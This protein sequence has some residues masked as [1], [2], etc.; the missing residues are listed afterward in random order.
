MDFHE[1]VEEANRAEKSAA[2]RKQY[3]ARLSLPKTLD[4]SPEEFV[5]MDYKDLRNDYERMVKVAKATGM[6]FRQVAAPVVQPE[7]EQKPVPKAEK[8]PG[9]ERQKPR[10]QLPIP[11]PL[12]KVEST[13]EAPSAP[14]KPVE[15]APGREIAPGARKQEPAPVQEEKPEPAE[16]EV[17]I[18][19]EK[20]GAPAKKAYAHEDE[21]ITFEREAPGPEKE[22]EEK[23]GHAEEE[24]AAPEPTQEPAPEFERRQERGSERERELEPESESKQERETGQGRE[25]E[26]DETEGAPELEPEPTKPVHEVQISQETK[27]AIGE[28]SEIPYIQHHVVISIAV[29][30]LLSMDPENEAQKKYSE[31]EEK[32]P[33]ESGKIDES[34]VKQR[35]LELTKQLFREK[36]VNQ[37]QKIKAEI[38]SLREMLSKK[39][40]AAKRPLS[41]VASFFNTM[42]VDQKMELAAAKESLSKEYKEN[43]ARTLDAFSSSLKITRSEEERKRIYETLV[44]DLENLQSQV[45]SLGD[46]YESFFLREHTLSL[47]K[48][49]D[50][51]ALKSEKTVAQGIESK[52]GE[53]KLEY[54]AEFLSFQEAVKK[55]VASITK[56]KKHEA[57][58][59]EMSKEMEL[60]LSIV[61]MSAEELM[62]YVH[63]RHPGEYKEL[64]SGKM[65][66][67]EFLSRARLLV[68]KDSGLGKDTINKYFGEI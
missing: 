11:K 5:D 46:K 19:E 47:Q 56:T 32:I 68:A 61:N 31:L 63:S 22:D 37:R 16:A 36:S 64:E 23:S 54:A 8:P 29:P 67:L 12:R 21:K 57:L 53:M 45:E 41:Y 50:L 3:P 52:I 30:P 55:E 1:L 6:G 43:L 26:R 24:P 38:T 27:A 2:E 58:E 65:T 4:F 9:Q 13:S 33:K 66:K 59:G 51:A 40:A 62:K 60:I 48:L 34:E 25:S 7:Q 14:S 39:P 15:H 49:R 20:I 17:P 35:M 42:E 44:S 28:A 10:F 18:P